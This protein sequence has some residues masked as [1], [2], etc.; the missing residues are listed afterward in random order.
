MQ[1]ILMNTGRSELQY[2]CGPKSV[3]GFKPK[4]KT[5]ADFKSG[6]A[7]GWVLRSKYGPRV[8]F[9][10]GLGSKSWW[11]CSVWANLAWEKPSGLGWIRPNPRI[12][13]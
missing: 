12:N 6:L 13:G 11:A 2:V 10:P 5:Y 3:W 1:N 8:S 4:E 7:E 9:G